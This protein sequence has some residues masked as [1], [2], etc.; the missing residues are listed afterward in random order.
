M[1]TSFPNLAGGVESGHHRD[2]QTDLDVALD[3]IDIPHVQHARGAYV[4][5]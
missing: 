2:S 3:D 4:W 1:E 5:H